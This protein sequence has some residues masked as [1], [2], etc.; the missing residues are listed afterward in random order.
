M[1]CP[2]CGRPTIQVTHHK[3]G[4]PWILD[5][6]PT[7]DGQ[8]LVVAGRGTALSGHLLVQARRMG[9]SVHTRHGVTCPTPY[10]KV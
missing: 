3:S 5:A 10:K 7:I 8:I 2:K 9:L 4:Q 1:N 6:N